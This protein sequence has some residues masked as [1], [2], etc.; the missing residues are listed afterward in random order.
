MTTQMRK[1]NAACDRLPRRNIFLKWSI[2]KWRVSVSSGNT[3]LV[4][5]RPCEEAVAQALTAEVSSGHTVQRTTNKD[6]D[7]GEG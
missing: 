5:N 2:M 6:A 3:T 4:C 7:V 1:G